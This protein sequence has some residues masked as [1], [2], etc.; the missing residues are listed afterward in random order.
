MLKYRAEPVIVRDGAAPRADEIVHADNADKVV[1]TEGSA[2]FPLPVM[3]FEPKSDYSL[4]MP[5][6]RTMLSSAP[7]RRTRLP[8]PVTLTIAFG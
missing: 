6:S 1:A 3:A 2:M 8:M 4:L 7:S 5:V